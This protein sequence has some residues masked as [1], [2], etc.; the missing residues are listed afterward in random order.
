MPN[1]NTT[2]EMQKQYAT[3]KN[4]NARAALHALYSTNKQGWGNWVVEQ[5]DIQPGMRILELGCGNGTMW[6]GRT[7][8]EGVELV[9]SDFSEG[10]L[11]A[12]KAN[13]AH[14]SR[15]EYRVVDAQDIPFDDG[16]FDIVIANHMLYHIPDADKALAEIARVLKA[17]GLFYA[18]TL[19][20]DN[21]KEM[22][23]L[24]T[25]FDARIDL[26]LDAVTRTFG[27]ETGGA[28]LAH[29]FAAVETRRYEDSLHITEAKPM[30]DYILSL[31]GIGNVN[32]I[33]A[34]D[35]VARFAAYVNG[36]FDKNGFFDVTKDAG[37]FMATKS[38]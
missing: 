37:M 11:E 33:I 31:Q 29:H 36:I 10:M 17:G 26:A 22:I 3:D 1:F 27:L 34:G 15:A 20:N 16:V 32:D 28:K 25:A 4:L 2:S 12:A 23:A 7:L 13:T 9:L 38:S 24:L 8:P 5:Y 18:T 35:E 21:F 30:I 19:G 14:L 6:S